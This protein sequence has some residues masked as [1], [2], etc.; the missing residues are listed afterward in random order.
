MLNKVKLEDTSIISQNLNINAEINRYNEQNDA[1][2]VALPQEFISKK[3]EEKE[4]DY[5]VNDIANKIEGIEIELDHS[6]EKENVEEIKQIK[7]PEIIEEAKYV[8]LNRRF[9]VDEKVD[10]GKMKAVKEAVIKYQEAKGSVVESLRLKELIAMCNNY[11]KG[12]IFKIGVAAKRLEEV[13]AVRNA[14]QIELVNLQEKEAA[15]SEDAKKEHKKALYQEM[16]K[17]K[18]FYAADI[19]RMHK[20][21][22]KA[23][24]K[25]L[26]SKRMQ[27]IK[28][29]VKGIRN[30][31]SGIKYEKAEDLAIQ[32]YKKGI[33][34]VSKID[35]VKLDEQVSKKLKDK[36]AKKVLEKQQKA[37]ALKEKRLREAE[38]RALAEEKRETK[39]RKHQVVRSN[40]NAVVAF[41]MNLIPLQVKNEN[42]EYKLKMIDLSET[43][44]SKTYLEQKDGVVYGDPDE[45]T[46]I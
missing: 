43:T 10:S 41:F 35:F 22:K 20:E 18:K 26:F 42:L 19:A 40:H 8:S 14:A 23:M 27:D 28:S 34:D 16:N 31:Y 15:L 5:G 36:R 39:R 17:N 33:T 32:C 12:K 44:S 37:K 11:T 38:K 13:K 4:R 25:D 1:S 29:L 30:E 46:F 3:V 6:F 21:E 2:K 7:E 24:G 9:E 45:A